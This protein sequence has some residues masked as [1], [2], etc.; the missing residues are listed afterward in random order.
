MENTIL[1][2]EVYKGSWACF[3]VHLA[4]PPVPSTTTVWCRAAWRTVTWRSHHNWDEDHLNEKILFTCISSTD[5]KFH[6]ASQRFSFHFREIYETCIEYVRKFFMQIRE[7]YNFGV[8][9]VH[10]YFTLDRI[11]QLKSGTGAPWRWGRYHMYG[12]LQMKSLWTDDLAV[13]HPF[14]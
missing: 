8:K 12:L 5:D 1:P 10:V 11:L 7:I 13:L 3:A 2:H 6:Q 4:A 9:V 14:Q